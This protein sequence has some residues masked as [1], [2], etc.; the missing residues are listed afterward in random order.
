PGD[1]TP[2]GGGQ[3]AIEDG[4]VFGL[5]EGRAI[6]FAVAINVADDF[7]G[8]LGGVAELHQ[9]G[10]HGVVDD[11]DDPAADEL[12]IFDEGEVGLDAGG[13]AIHHEA[14]GAGGSENR[15]LGI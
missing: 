7:A 8:L 3:G 14:N 11:F 2:A 4:N 1:G 12:F 6:D 13:V 5:D 9:R 15:D 10:R